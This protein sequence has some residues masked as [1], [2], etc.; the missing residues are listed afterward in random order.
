MSFQFLLGRPTKGI[1]GDTLRF[2]YS[3]SDLCQLGRC[4]S[5]CLRS[6][7]RSISLSKQLLSSRSTRLCLLKV[8][9]A[10]LL[11]LIESGSLCLELVKSSK[12][13]P[14]PFKPTRDDRVQLFLGRRWRKPCIVTAFGDDW[15]NL[16]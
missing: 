7:F 14:L 6:R 12:L 8:S 13:S 1:S 4:L 2:R 15:F 5:L 9:A 3:R 10:L 16:F 11:N